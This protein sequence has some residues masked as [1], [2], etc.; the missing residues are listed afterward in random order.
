MNAAGGPFFQQAEDAAF[1]L[2]DSLYGIT[3]SMKLLG[4]WNHFNYGSASID[5]LTGL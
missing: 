3:W 1:I 5:G 2:P 4:L